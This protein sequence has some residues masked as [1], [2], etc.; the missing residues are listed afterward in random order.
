MSELNT[1]Y[2]DDKIEY[3]DRSSFDFTDEKE[4][5][6]LA[7]SQDGKFAVTF[8]TGKCYFESSFIDFKILFK[9]NFFFYHFNVQN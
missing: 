1:I 9:P 4:E 8:D 5:Y 3:K 7:I 2:V 6:Q